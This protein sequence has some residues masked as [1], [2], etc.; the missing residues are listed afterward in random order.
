MSLWK[1]TWVIV[2]GTEW[3]LFRWDMEI[4]LGWLVFKWKKQVGDWSSKGTQ[5]EWELATGEHVHCRVREVY[6]LQ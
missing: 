6:I 1:F 3:G 4:Y 2:D 5:I